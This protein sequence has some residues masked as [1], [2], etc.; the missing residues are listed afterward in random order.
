[1][2]TFFN[3]HKSTATIIGLSLVFVVSIGLSVKALT[4]PTNQTFTGVIENI[5]ITNPSGDTFGSDTWEISDYTAI[6][7]EEDLIVG[8]TSTLT[9]DVTVSGQLG[10]LEKYQALTATTTITTAM[11]GSTFYISGADAQYTLPATTTDAGLVYRFVVDGAMTANHTIV[12]SDGGNDIEGTL[13]VA[14]A[15]VDCASED[16]LTFV[17]DGE[18]VGD[19]VELRFNG[20]DWL[21]GDSGVLTAAKLTCTAT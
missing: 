18:N 8:G 5:T 11:S 20:T 10:Y 21:I 2:K 16:T 3:K 6:T 4:T 1:M 15:V 9:G 14:G 17:A 12:T 13:I 19:Y 7:L